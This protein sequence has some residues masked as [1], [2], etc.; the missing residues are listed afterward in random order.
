MFTAGEELSSNASS[1]F[2]GGALR[3]R[4]ITMSLK[5]ARAMLSALDHAMAGVGSNSADQ[6]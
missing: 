2:A 3:Q 5:G 1:V 6:G 4:H